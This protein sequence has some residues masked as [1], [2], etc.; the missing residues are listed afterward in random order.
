MKN[1]RGGKTL[2]EIAKESI[3]DFVVK[4]PGYAHII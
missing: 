4:T 2:M 3:Q 1:V